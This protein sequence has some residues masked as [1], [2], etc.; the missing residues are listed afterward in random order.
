MKALRWHW[1][2]EGRLWIVG[3]STLTCASV[4]LVISSDSRRPM[5]L[6][7][8]AQCDMHLH[9][10]HTLPAPLLRYHPVTR[11]GGT[12]VLVWRSLWRLSGVR[13]A[14]GE[15]CRQRAVIRSDARPQSP[16][17]PPCH[18]AAQPELALNHPQS[19]CGGAA[20]ILPHRA[21]LSPAPGPQLGA[22]RLHGRPSDVPATPVPAHPVLGGID[23]S[24]LRSLAP[25]DICSL[26]TSVHITR[27]KY[28]SW[29]C[30]NQL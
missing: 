28:T 20:V 24:S 3:R 22:R 4:R 8:R 16:T 14:G 25:E 12:S 6:R 5:P 10:T 18:R 19:G 15:C 11:L 21:G 9:P 30:N 26:L 23:S 13:V 17:H 7:S 27:H 29:R 2:M 1:N